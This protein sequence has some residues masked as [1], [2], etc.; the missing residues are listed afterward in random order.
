MAEATSDRPAWRKTIDSRLMALAALFLVWLLVILGRL[1]YLQVVAREE[2]QAYADKQQNKTLKVPAKRGDI[3]DRNG[4][5]LAFSVDAHVPFAVPPEVKDR[6]ATAAAICAAAGG[7][8]SAERA[9]LAE[10]LGYKRPWV[11]LWPGVR[12]H[13]SPELAQRIQALDLPGIGIDKEERR[14]YPKG[15][16]AAH[17]LGYVLLDNRGGAGVEAVYDACVRGRDGTSRIQKDAKQ[18]VF[19]RVTVPPTAGATLE[20]TI[21]ST[22]QY[23]V[24]RE[25]RFGV[26]DNNAESGV[27]IVMDP[28]TGE[29]LALANEPT[30]DPNRFWQYPAA[31]LT[32][33]GRN[34]AVQDLYEPGST[35]KIV[36]GSAALEERVVG[37]NDPIDVSEGCLRI[38]GRR[39]DDVHRYGVLSYTDVLVKS[40]NVGA[41]KVGLRTGAE[42]LTRYIRR[43]GFG[44]RLSP[45]FRG[46]NPG[47]V[48]D[49]SKLNDS[50]VA[51]ISMGYQI[52]VT[53]LQMVTAASAI[54]NGGELVQPR[55]VRAVIEG[56]RRVEVK[57]HRVRRAVDPTTAALLASIMQEVV[58]RG[59][60]TAAKIPGYR[61]AGKTG[62]AQRLIDGRYSQSEYNASFVG[63]LPA[64]APR[65]AIIVLI[66]SPHGRGYYGGT[67]SAPIFRR[68]AEHAIRH[69]GIPPDVDPPRAILASRAPSPGPESA[70]AVAAAAPSEHSADQ[71]AVPN[72]VGMSARAAVRE[73]V[74]RGMIV[75][76]NGQG[77]V[78]AQDPPPGT[79][80]QP[81]D[82]CAILLGRP[83]PQGQRPS[84]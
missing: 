64:S 51:S 34:R 42:R 71:E 4:R 31:D 3:V 84:Q 5:L 49:P 45:D 79:R 50:A 15:Q 28:R 9:V 27:A 2:L 69:Y 80:V 1:V 29:V 7:C 6:D 63:F 32:N 36:S 37:P 46:E 62:T 18:R 21:D 78:V 74:R 20:L 33:R 13:V 83:E 58:E 11:P 17:V 25:L 8:S 30:F 73:A 38:G 23:F 53:P 44:S 82:R 16:L 66:S 14:H 26:A 75:S 60:A 72:L 48:W 55:V 56:G 43:F 81:G 76:L 35:F 10:R 39:I 40:S 77:E 12:R 65:L 52:G 59:T 19:N 67:V 54:A 61:I 41:A 68:I 24:E 22:L 57:P 70:V 47:I